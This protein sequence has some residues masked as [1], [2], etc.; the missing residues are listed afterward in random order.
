MTVN[1]L[2][3]CAVKIDRAHHHFRG[4]QNAIEAFSNRN[5]NPVITDENE[6]NTGRK[7]DRFS[8]RE[9]IPSEFSAFIGDIAHNLMSALDSLAMAIAIHHAKGV[10][11]ENKMNHIYFPINWDSGWS[12]VKAER[13]FE[14]VSSE[15]RKLIEAVEVHARNNGD[16][17]RSLH[18]LNII[19]KHRSIVA[20][21]AALGG[22]QFFPSGKDSEPFPPRQ[23][24]FVPAFPLKHGDILS[25][26]IWTEPEFDARAHFAFRIA[27]GEDQVLAR[28]DVMDTLEEMIYAVEGTIEIFSRDFFALN[29]WR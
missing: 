16:H 20:V 9:N 15:A 29:G 7:V 25:I 2:F 28:R 10:S 14:L 12:K 21:A 23:G 26:R 6:F 19:D 18:L 27:F 1:P 24:A 13:F 22:V 5:P 3:S 11:L 4:L 8:V 17:L